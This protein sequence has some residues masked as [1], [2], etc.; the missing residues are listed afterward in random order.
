MQPIRFAV[1]LLSLC[2]LGVSLAATPEPRTLRD[3]NVAQAR[4]LDADHLREYG[5]QTN[6]LVR[7][8]L[9]ADRVSR[10]V[11]MSAESIALRKG[12]PVEFQMITADSGKDYESQAVAF[13][14]ANDIHQALEFIGLHPGQCADSAALRYWPQ[15]DRVRMTFRFPNTDFTGRTRPQPNRR[16]PSPN[17][18]SEIRAEHLVLDTRTGK[19]LPETGFVF[20]GSERVK[21]VAPATG[22]VYAADAFTPGSIV[23]L[24][25][26]P[27][28]VLDVPRKSSQHEVYTYQVPNPDQPL[29]A[30]ALIEVLLEPYFRDSAQHQFH[31]SL[32]VTPGKTLDPTYALVTADGLTVNTNRS[33]KGFLA[34]LSRITAPDRD[35][36]VV[37]RPDDAL[38]LKPMPSLAQLLSSLDTERGIRLEAPPEGHPYFR[39]FLPNQ[40]HRSRENRSAAAAELYLSPLGTT[41]TGELVFVETEWKEDNSP[42]VFHEARMAVPTP[43]RLEKALADKTDPPGVMLIFAPDT[44]SYGALRSFALP[45]LKRHMILYV[46]P[47]AKPCDT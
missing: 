19:T 27:A 34:T 29:P 28:T 9:I 16:S 43:D 24:Y 4:A 26:D 41:T 44:L 46:F 17:P 8:G 23:S 37:F 20:T 39:S 12:D 31:Y 35:I 5:C 15:G 38:P 42:P 30:N 7:P 33:L 32:V 2:W 36:F 25:N 47:P 21:A 14:S 45:L 10:T 22:T 3:V 11:R 18:F 13:A 6:F 1:L 40:A